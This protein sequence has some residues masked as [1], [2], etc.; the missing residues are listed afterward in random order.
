MYKAGNW[1][2]FLK[3]LEYSTECPSDF[4]VFL[5][6]T[7]AKNPD[8]FLEHGTMELSTFFIHL[9][10]T[11]V[12]DPLWKELNSLLPESFVSDVHWAVIKIWVV[13]NLVFSKQ[14]LG[15]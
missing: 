11:G 7:K 8:K 4:N 3:Q 5:S 15:S 6:S 9:F 12:H 2:L 14:I 13:M 1:R 10:S